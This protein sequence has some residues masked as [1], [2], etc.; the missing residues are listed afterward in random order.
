MSNDLRLIYSLIFLHFI[1]SHLFIPQR[2]ISHIECISEHDQVLA[3]I[4]WG[5]QQ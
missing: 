4:W 1:P 5:G 3:P 2:L